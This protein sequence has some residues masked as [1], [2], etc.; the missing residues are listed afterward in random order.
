MTTQT[1]HP[2]LTQPMCCTMSS[3]SKR[4]YEE[5]A[6]VGNGQPEYQR[7]MEDLRQRIADGRLAV[8]DPIP[9]TAK[10]GSQYDVSSTVVRRAVTEL[11]AEGL[12]Y[13]QA[14]KGVF[15]R[16]RPT[17]VTAQPSAAELAATVQRLEA[18]LDAMATRLEELERERKT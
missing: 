1:L 9:S 12:L 13:G 6:V 14:G 16:A 2:L 3:S 4:P 7:V 15:V 10:L 17:P 5:G 8:G 18:R 11:T